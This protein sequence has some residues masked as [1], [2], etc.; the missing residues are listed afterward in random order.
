MPRGECF[1]SEDDDAMLPGLKKAIKKGEI[2]KPDPM[3]FSSEISDDVLNS[4]PSRNDIS[5]E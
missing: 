5:L 4:R 3:D 1:G 2:K